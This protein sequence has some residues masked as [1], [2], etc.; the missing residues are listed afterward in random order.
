MRGTIGLLAAAMLAMTVP[1]PAVAG[2][3]VMPAGLATAVAKSTLKV[4][5]QSAW[6]RWSARPSKKG[7]AWTLDGMALNELSF[8]AGIA[9]GEPLLKERNKKDKPLP[10]FSA[11]M[12]APELVQFFE[13]TNRIVLNTS[14]FEIDSVEPV[15][16]AGHDGVRFTYHFSVEGD[17][18]RRNGEARAAVIG[19]KL[20]LIN[21]SAPAIHY[22]DANIAEVRAIMDSATL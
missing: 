16:L 13:A 12:L 10:R 6:N 11:Q 2:W 18:L 7:E 3:K 20:Y 5:P 15:R 14:L 22:F 9:P 19:G 4:T 8:F 17:G 21:F 1:G